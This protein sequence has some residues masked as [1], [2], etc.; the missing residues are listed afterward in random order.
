MPYV[1]RNA[2]RSDR[3]TLRLK[4]ARGVDRE[5]SSFFRPTFPHGDMSLAGLGQTHRLIMDRLG[6]GKAIMR[7]G[8]A[9]VANTHA[10]PLQ[11]LRPSPPG[12]VHGR[13]VA[14]RKRQ[15]IVCMGGPAKTNR[16]RCIACCILGNEHKRC[17]TIRDERAVA[18]AQGTGCN[19][20]LGTKFAWVEQLPGG[21]T[22]GY[23][24]EMD[25]AGFGPRSGELQ[26]AFCGSFNNTPARSGLA[27]RVR[28]R[29]IFLC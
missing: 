9:E 28:S 7:P 14:A 22:K 16:A 4:A 11:S 8:E 18:P 24:S 10:R 26:P 1:H 23:K 25:G 17:R 5:Y 6:D 27:M 15:K 19:I 21:D 12:T 20:I 2:G 3:M 13:G 29:E